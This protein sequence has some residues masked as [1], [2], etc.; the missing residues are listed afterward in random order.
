MPYQCPTRLAS[1]RTN[2]SHV[3]C[4]RRE[5][6]SAV[7]LSHRSLPS[8]LI[9][10]AGA[11][12][13]NSVH[14]RRRQEKTI[15]LLDDEDSELDED[16]SPSDKDMHFDD[17]QRQLGD[18]ENFRGSKI[19]YPSRDDPAHVDIDFFDIKCLDP[20]AYLSSPI[21]NF[22]IRYL[23]QLG[24]PPDTSNCDY[25][26]FNTF[27]YSKLKEA[28]SY[29]GND[30][31]SFA[32][33]RRWWRGIN[34]FHKAY[35]LIP[36]HE[37]LHWSLIIICIPYKDKENGPIV[38][39]LDS[40]GLHYSRPIFENIRRFIREEWEFLTHECP[41]SDLPW[42]SLPRRIEERTVMVPQQKNDYDC[43]LFV[44]YFMERFIAEAPKR[45][46]RKDL[47]MF[48]RQWF[49]PA[50]ASALRTKIRSLLLKEFETANQFRKDNVMTKQP[51]QQKSPIDSEM[52]L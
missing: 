29:K 18:L 47:Q 51:F 50:E 42:T 49:R 24:S 4:D 35:I 21:M 46:I 14:A 30:N 40:L 52:V 8:R 37:D 45:L 41:S 34:I 36:V 23:Q 19:S 28:V 12:H 16:D 7:L 6:L 33:F 2:H 9:Q 10:K 25:Q 17:M 38:L 39:H 1:N 32:K 27:F 20:E 26:F 22:Y 3:N 31:T 11:P 43:G 13:I 5:N 15:V 48:S 44:L